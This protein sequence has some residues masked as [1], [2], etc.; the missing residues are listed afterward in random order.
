MKRCDADKLDKTEG[1]LLIYKNRFDEDLIADRYSVLVERR[2]AFD[3]EDWHHE[4][5]PYSGR[6]WGRSI[7]DPIEPPDDVFNEELEAEAEEQLREEDKQEWDALVEDLHF[8]SKYP[9]WLEGSK[10]GTTG[11]VWE[12]DTTDFALALQAAR[13]DLDVWDSFAV[14]I[15]DGEV[16]IDR[17]SEYD[18][19]LLANKP[20]VFRL[21]QKDP[22]T[23]EEF[24]VAW[25]ICEA[26]GLT[27]FQQTLS[28]SSR[29]M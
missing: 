29:C 9:L 13:Q 18:R 16:Y 11:L 14:Y 28:D 22:D 27:D 12:F 24:S 23:G 5:A 17:G 3:D 19:N 4:D 8:N 20:T 26:L 1:C 2:N 15:K 25:N 21:F 10:P 7:F 6:V